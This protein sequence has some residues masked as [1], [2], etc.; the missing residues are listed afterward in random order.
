MPVFNL[1]DLIV[2]AADVVVGGKKYVFKTLTIE[3]RGKVQARL[4][5]IVPN[6]LEVAKKTLEGMPRASRD[7]ID[8]V[9]KYADQAYR[10]WPP[11]VESEEGIHWLTSDE[12]LQRLVLSLSSGVDESDSMIDEV[13]RAMNMGTL[14]NV[15]GFILSGVDPRTID[16]KD[17]SRGLPR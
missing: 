3:Q 17:L 6:P 10:F 13:M 16:P 1:D 15:I 12:G 4:R 8:T 9:W 2:P 5:E 14:G 11:L 7:T